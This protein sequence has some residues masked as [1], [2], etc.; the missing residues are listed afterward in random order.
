MDII[1]K[2]LTVVI[3]LIGIGVIL[4]WVGVIYIALHFAIKLW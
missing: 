3:W 4:F 1:E 2:I